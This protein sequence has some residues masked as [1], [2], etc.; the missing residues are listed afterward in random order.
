MFG[1]RACG[2]LTVP[3]L[4]QNRP[5]TPF[6]LFA[7]SGT[8]WNILQAHFSQR[9][10]RLVL[11]TRAAAGIDPSMLVGAAVVSTL[12]SQQMAWQ[13]PTAASWSA[14]NCHGAKGGE[15]HGTSASRASEGEGAGSAAI[16][17]CVRACSSLLPPGPTCQGYI[18][19]RRRPCSLADVAVERQCT[20]LHLQL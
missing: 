8:Q 13:P 4:S 20:S 16:V 19:T 17:L 5:I 9:R 3:Q 15:G 10:T 2:R 11:A 6:A 1:W 7:W 14:R 18:T 12:Q